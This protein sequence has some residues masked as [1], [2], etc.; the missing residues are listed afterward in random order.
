[1]FVCLSVSAPLPSYLFATGDQFL[2]LF[3]RRFLSLL[4]LFQQLSCNFRRKYY[5]SILSQSVI[6]MKW[7]FASATTGQYR[8]QLVLSW[9]ILSTFFISHRIVW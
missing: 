1:M 9:R 6:W 5:G 8:K 2:A 4:G 3:L 7:N